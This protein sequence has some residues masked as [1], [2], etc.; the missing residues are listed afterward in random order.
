MISTSYTLLKLFGV[1]NADCSEGANGLKCETGL[2]NVKADSSQFETILRLG[3]GVIAVIAVLVIVIA[4]LRFILGQGN[5][6][7]TAKARSTIIYAL[8]GLVVALSAQAI[9]GFVLGSA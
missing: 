6:Q 4:G 9:V 8:V 2:P 3:F 7:E 5:P 1:V